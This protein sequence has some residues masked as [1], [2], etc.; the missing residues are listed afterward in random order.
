MPSGSITA[1]WHPHQQTQAAT[2]HRRGAMTSTAPTDGVAMA[3]LSQLYVA[4]LDGTVPPQGITGGV[5][6]CCKTAVAAGASNTLYLAWRHVYEGNMRDIAFT[7]SR[8]GGK[9][10]APPVRV[11]EERV[12]INGCPDDG[13]AMAVDSTGA[14]HIVWPSVVTERGGPGE[15]AVSR[16]DP[17]RACLHAPRADPDL[18]AGRTIPSWQSTARTRSQ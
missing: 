12:E 10:F 9:T 18:R 17:R 3:Q 5:C 4:A 7:V 8:D 15:G 2:E 13:P 1:S 11:S 16:D 14:V 6:Y